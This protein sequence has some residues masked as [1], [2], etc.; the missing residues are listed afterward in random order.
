MRIRLHSL[1]GFCR[2]I[3]GVAAVEFALTVPVLILLLFGIIETGRALW[4]K[5]SLQY[6]VE[7]AAR[8][9]AVYSTCI[10]AGLSTCGVTCASD[11]A[12]KTYA[13]TQV[14]DQTIS[15][16]AFT[17]SHPVD[18]SGHAS[19]C[20]AGSWTFTLWFQSLS[21]LP[22]VRNTVVMPPIVL[23]SNSCR[24]NMSLPE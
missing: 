4:A 24:P 7:R 18:A 23:A 13:V 14:Y 20:V 22:I 8:C 5:N 9:G 2:H 16:G 6:A 1:G 3:A 19:L 12:I 10:N 11:A 17:V 21:K 15:A